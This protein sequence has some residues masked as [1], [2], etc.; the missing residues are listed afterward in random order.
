MNAVSSATAAGRSVEAAC[1]GAQMFKARARTVVTV[2][3]EGLIMSFSQIAVIRIRLR[4]FAL[5]INSHSISDSLQPRDI[6][7]PVAAAR[8]S[9]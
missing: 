6:G 7:E 8:L 4:R 2:S 1:S 3:V 5:T 9:S